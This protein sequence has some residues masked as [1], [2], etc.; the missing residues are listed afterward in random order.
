MVLK[1]VYPF[2]PISTTT[3]PA[4][5]Q[6]IAQI[7]WDG[8]RVLLYA[9]GNETKLVNRRLNERTT[10]YPEL[11][12]SSSFCKADSVILDGEIIAFDQN[13]PSF[14]E[15]MKRDR[16]KVPQKIKVA[17]VRNPV[18]YM[19]FDILFYNGEWVTG[20]PL[21]ERQALLEDIIVPR[22]NLQL[23]QNFPDGSALFE[24]MKQYKM[25][26]IVYKDLSSTY[27]IN[28]K[29]GRWR[30]RKVFQDLVAVVGG[31]TFRDR[32]VNVLLLGIYAE[33]GSL[34]YIGHAGTGRLTQKD[35]A[36]LTDN[37]K[38]LQQAEKPFANEPERS[39]E[40]VWVRPALTV[41]VEFLELTPGGTMRHPSIQAIVDAD[42]KECTVAQLPSS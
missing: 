35:W 3:T 20:K 10:Q 6:W 29:D 31:V 32:I 15:V 14:Y 24:L 17:S 42:A 39:K 7:K 30:K 19:V 21:S 13:K 23:A 28:G 5:Q 11:L 18:T 26:G 27:M 8:V 33:D 38:E 9:D 36:A 16:M 41:K 12:D 34:I 2:E 25:E 4:G 37:T 40:A 1:P 22:P